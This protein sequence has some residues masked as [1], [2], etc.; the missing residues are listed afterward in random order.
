MGKTREN[1]Q[2][3]KVEIGV[4]SVFSHECDIIQQAHVDWKEEVQR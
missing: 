3:W 2:G 1:G 4:I